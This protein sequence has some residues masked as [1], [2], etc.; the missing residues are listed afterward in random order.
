MSLYWVCM[1][2]PGGVVVTQTPVFLFNPLQTL[3]LSLCCGLLWA[4]R[5]MGRR[6]Q[7]NQRSP[8]STHG[9]GNHSVDEQ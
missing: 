9:A 8:D 3:S 1:G 2:H 6:T 4:F 5:E 7:R